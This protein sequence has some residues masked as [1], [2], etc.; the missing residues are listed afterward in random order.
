[1]QHFRSASFFVEGKSGKLKKVLWGV[2]ARERFFGAWIEHRSYKYAPFDSLLTGEGEWDDTKIKFRVGPA[3]MF[4]IGQF[5]IDREKYA[6]H[7]PDLPQPDIMFDHDLFV[8]NK[9]HETAVHKQFRKECPWCH[10]AL[11][12]MDKIWLV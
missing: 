1:M 8:S 12:H 10:V 7:H 11:F 5:F 2:D 4:A 9:F 6:C 3:H